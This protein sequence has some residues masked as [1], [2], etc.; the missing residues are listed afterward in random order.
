MSGMHYHSEGRHVCGSW[1]SCI[2][3]LSHR[4]ALMF[5]QMLTNAAFSK[6]QLVTAP[7][8]EPSVVQLCDKPARQ[9]CTVEVLLVPDSISQPASDH[10]PQQQGP[11]NMRQIMVRP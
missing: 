9:L 2:C 5:Q 8:A 10:Q 6:S 11:N 1:P 3:M 4:N 7:S